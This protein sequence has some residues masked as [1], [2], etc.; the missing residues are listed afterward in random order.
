M[1]WGGLGGV[2][3]DVMTFLARAHMFDATQ[4]CFCS[5]FAHVPD[6]TQDMGWVGRGGDVMT[7]LPHSFASLHL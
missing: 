6:V 7:F 3:G 1:G 5:S 2:G 4:H